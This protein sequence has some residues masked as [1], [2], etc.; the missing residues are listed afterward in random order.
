MTSHNTIPV[1]FISMFH[2]VEDKYNFYITSNIIFSILTYKF[3]NYCNEVK[4][5]SIFYKVYQLITV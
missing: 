1:F 3:L 4:F 5:D 2:N